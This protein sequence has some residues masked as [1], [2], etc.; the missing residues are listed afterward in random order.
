MQNFDIVSYIHEA[1]PQALPREVVIRCLDLLVEAC[2]DAKRRGYTP[3][4]EGLMDGFL[5]AED[6]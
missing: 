2:H 6:R 4:F 3:G 5:A 1:E